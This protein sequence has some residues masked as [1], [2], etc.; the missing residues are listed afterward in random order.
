MKKQEMT[1][2]S[3]TLFA[4]IGNTS[5]DT[6]F[7]SKGQILFEKISGKDTH[8]LEEYLQKIYNHSSLDRLIITSVNRISLNQFLDAVKKHATNLDIHLIQRNDMEL[9]CKEHHLKV[10]N[11]DIL[12]SDL[13]CDIIS[14][15]N[16]A[17]QIIIDL[18]TAS[19][20]LFLDSN[21]YFHGCQI[22]PSLLS[23]PKVLNASTDLLGD[24]ALTDM[25][26]L[27]SL[28]TQECISSGAIN[29]V[30]ALIASMIQAI[31]KEY[32]CPNC[33]IYLTGGNA[34]YILNTLKLFTDENVIYDEY[35]ILKGLMRLSGYDVNLQLS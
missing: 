20:I 18:G 7:L 8:A 29:G 23:F 6:L 17:G 31:K 22:F 12:G 11:L 14:K 35:H 21:N 33:D 3:N 5:I 27:V 13:L 24:N 9:Y 26:P 16:K 2:F 30:S 34:K 25:P 19:K 28:K 32:D 1:D 10:D 15:D 4:D